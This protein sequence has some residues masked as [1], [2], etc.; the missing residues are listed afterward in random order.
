LRG[1][2]YANSALLVF[3]RAIPR[4]GWRAALQRPSQLFFA[5]CPIAL[6]IISSHRPKAEHDFLL[7]TIYL[8]L[9]LLSIG[10]KKED[11][12]NKFADIGK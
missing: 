8:R 1:I 10:K 3:H 6:L 9:L 2:A 5:Q 4:G 11:F 12:R 7:L